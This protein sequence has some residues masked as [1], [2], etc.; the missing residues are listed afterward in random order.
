ML[1]V[2]NVGG[3]GKSR[4]CKNPA[5]GETRRVFVCLEKYS[6][7]YF[8]DLLRTEA[9]GADLYGLDVAVLFDAH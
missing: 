8:F 9:A 7:D 3:F 5:G 6:S 1:F 4:K 2:V